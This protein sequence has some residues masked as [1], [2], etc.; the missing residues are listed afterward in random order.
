MLLRIK[1]LLKNLVLAQF[2]IVLIIIRTVH[3]YL[4]T[5]TKKNF[6]FCPII[7]HDEKNNFNPF[8]STS[9]YCM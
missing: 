6:Y 7:I 9:S 2:N 5:Y 4:H 8:T 3:L 1:K